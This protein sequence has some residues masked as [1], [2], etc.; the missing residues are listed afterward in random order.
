MELPDKPKKVHERD[1]RGRIKSLSQEDAFN[2]IR[3]L[4]GEGYSIIS[5]KFT[6]VDDRLWILHESCGREYLISLTNLRRGRKCPKCSR[7]ASSKHGQ[8]ARRG[9]IER[10]RRVIAKEKDYELIGNH[11]TNI[12][13]KMLI[14][15]H[16]CG[17][18]WLC[19]VNNFRIGKRC[20]NCM[21]TRHDSVKEAEKEEI[22]IQKIRQSLYN[23]NDWE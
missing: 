11:Y 3:T 14:K 17:K 18:V 7:S 15:H 6:R 23:M 16:V 21:D 8:A 19:T 20:P 13:T 5:D 4:L 12:H 2:E 9:N 22:A 1:E 10:A